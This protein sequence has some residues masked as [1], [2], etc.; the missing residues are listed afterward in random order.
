MVV[1]AYY[2]FGET[3]VERQAQALLTNGIEVDVIC[4]GGSSQPA[5]ATIDGVQVY[6]LPVQRNKG[7]SFVAQLFEYLAFFVLASI[8]LSKLHLRRHYDVVQVHNLPDFLVFVALIPKL[9]GASIILDLHDLM[10]EFY[11]ERIQLS[12]NSFPVRLIRWQEYLS[13]RFANHVITVTELWRQ[14][15]IERGQPA[16]RVSVVMNV[17]DD[18]VFNRDTVAAMSTDNDHNSVQCEAADGRFRLIYHGVMDYR[19]GLDL[20]LEAINLVR[21]SAPEVHLTLHGGG[22]YRATLVSLTDELGLQD[23]VQFSNRLVPTVELPKLLREADLAIVPYR[24]GLFTGEI[25]PTKL[26]EY[27]AL[28]IPSIAAR[29]PAIATYFDE[30]MI[31]FFTPG[32]VDD[33]VGSIM[34]LYE[35]RTLLTKLANGAEKFN[36]HYNWARVSAEYVA[37]VEKLG[38][39]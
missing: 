15:L 25:L 30:T 10:P 20:A 14:S 11:A 19:H 4:L 7:G 13:C 3:R 16:D 29:T 34:K 24:D 18:R 9:T 37:L 5:Q 21:R 12:M 36:R 38:A 28:G 27:A 1:H 23:N 39:R 6:R 8:C 32:S 33:L 2:P 26:M 35:D 17:A 31:E 22:P